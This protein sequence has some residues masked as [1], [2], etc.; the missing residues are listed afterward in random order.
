MSATLF[1]VH[2]LTECDVYHGKNHVLYTDNWYTSLETM[3]VGMER[4][5]LC[6]GTVKTNRKGLPKEGIFPKKGPNKK[7]R[8]T[9]KCMQRPGFDIYL[10]AWQDNKPVHMLS[11]FKPYHQKI[12]RK[13]ATQGWRKREIDSHSLI[14]AY[15]FGPYYI[16]KISPYYIH[17]ICPLLIHLSCLFFFCIH[18][19]IQVFY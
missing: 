1:P 9:V 3:E 13:S 2:E 8:G 18:I 14:P 4:R 16:H 7:P 6:A 17:N 10:T 12:M 11:T 15:N 5:I 19:A